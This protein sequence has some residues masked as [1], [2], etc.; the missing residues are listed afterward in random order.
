[1]NRATM[2]RDG[3]TLMVAFCHDNGL[4]IPSMNEH[5][6]EAWP[7][8]ECAYYRPDRGIVV[9][10]DRCAVIGRGGRAWSFPGYIIDRTPYGVVAHE[11]G[12]HVD[13]ELSK[14]KY[15]DAPL[16]NYWAAL[17]RKVQEAAGEK[18]ITGYAAVNHAEW[19]A[20][21]FRLFCTNPDLL[22]QIRPRTYRELRAAG[23]QP[24]IKKDWRTVL[25]TPL[26]PAR[27]L[28]MAARRVEEA[29]AAA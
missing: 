3:V 11:L 13:M 1:M 6:G 16:G 5:A 9:C 8:R 22:L 14:A 26:A 10:V 24:V 4:P 23:L 15:P 29:R 18:G 28:A 12:H 7:F 17:S 2:M 27:T 25:E 21:A 19:F 20:E